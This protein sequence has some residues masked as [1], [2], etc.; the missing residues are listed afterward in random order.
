MTRVSGACLCGSVSYESD[1]EPL[2][3]AICHCQNCQRQSGSAF[4]VNVG[5]PEP[6]LHLKGEEHLRTYVD[7]GSSGQKV[8]RQFCGLC[9]SPLISRVGSIPGLAF[10]KSGTLHDRSWVKPSVQLWC[11][12]AQPWVA[13]DPPLPSF[14]GNPPG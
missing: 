10:I 12:S 8:L 13:L 7:Q 3:T 1:V 9:G 4:S 6:A 2:M 11:D 5:V 14:P